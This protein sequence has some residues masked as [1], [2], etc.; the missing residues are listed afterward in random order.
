MRGRRVELKRIDLTKLLEILEQMVENR[1][2]KREKI[3]ELGS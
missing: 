2:N 1:E 3:T